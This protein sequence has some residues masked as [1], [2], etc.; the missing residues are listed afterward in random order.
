M[1]SDSATPIPKTCVTRR[2]I[3]KM[4]AKVNTRDL[5]YGPD[6]KMTV[7]STESLQKVILSP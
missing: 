7:W 2:A 3:F 1:E 4:A 5:Q 6:L